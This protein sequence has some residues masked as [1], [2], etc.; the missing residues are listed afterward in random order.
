MVKRHINVSLENLLRAWEELSADASFG[1]MT[2]EEFR[3][4]TAPAF[5]TRQQIAW[6]DQERA[7]LMA[8]RSAA[9]RDAIGQYLL[10]INAIKGSPAHGEDSPLY[11]SLGY[12]TRTERR[13]GLTRK[14]RTESETQE[15]A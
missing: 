1:G 9:D 14:P 13:S 4:A 6:L 11:R 7:S 5:M 12:K 15:A 10:V 2:L 8:A 3:T